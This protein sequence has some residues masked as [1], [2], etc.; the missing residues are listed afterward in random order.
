VPAAPGGPQGGAQEPHAPC[1]SFLT[2]S[3]TCTCTR[4]AGASATPLC[5][6]WP[7]LLTCLARWWT[8]TPTCAWRLELCAVAPAEQCL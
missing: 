5:A 2:M 6:T 1:P 4:A 3:A 7:P 8:S